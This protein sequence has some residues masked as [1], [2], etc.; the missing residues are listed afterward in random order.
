MD[1]LIRSW[2]TTWKEDTLPFLMV[3]LP[4]FGAP[5]D[6][7]AES[8]WAALRQQQLQTLRIPHT[9]LAVAIDLGEWNDIHPLNK[10]EVGM[11]LALQA[12]KK[13]YGL[14]V[15]ADG[16]MV[17]NVHVSGSLVQL[18]WE[19]LAGGLITGKEIRHFELAG[20][21]R[22]FYPATAWRE[23]ETIQVQSPSVL[24]P[25]Y[26]RYAWSDNP[27]GVNLYNKAGLPASPFKRKLR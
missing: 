1:Q 26:I 3:Q 18:K 20:K 19:N 24:H 23:G 4:N 25:R 9:G 7:P 17:S 6:K 21:Q 12:Y 8:N 22:K 10:K 5:L 11:R 16:P 27:E 15:E 2:R 14:K 13:V